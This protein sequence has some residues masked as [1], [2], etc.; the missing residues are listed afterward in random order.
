MAPS[1]AS[2]TRREFL[3]FLLKITGI[4]PKQVKYGTSKNPVWIMTFAGYP[5]PGLTTLV[6]FGASRLAQSMYRGLDIG[7]EL[8]LTLAKPDSSSV[9]DLVNIVVEY[10]RNGNSGERR[11]SIEYNGVSAPGYPPHYLFTDA[12]T[13]TPKFSGR[14]RFGN[15]WI[16]LLAAVPLDDAEL[17][18]YDRSFPKLISKLRREDEIAKYPRR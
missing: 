5:K 7:Y 6:S 9:K 15:Q 8:S 1:T 11:A 2:Q 18:Q 13:C 17:R 10:L 4:Q 3:Q 12:V 16:E 14:K